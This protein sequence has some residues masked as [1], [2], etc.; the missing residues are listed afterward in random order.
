MKLITNL[1]LVGVL[2]AG[3]SGAIWLLNAA[4][5]PFFD[6]GSAQAVAAQKMEELGGGEL[7]DFAHTNGKNY[8]A[9]YRQGSERYDIHVES[10]KVRVQTGLPLCNAAPK[11]SR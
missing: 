7:I 1:L 6:S 4:A 9:I 2:G 10:G 3:L 5:S 8:R 11:A